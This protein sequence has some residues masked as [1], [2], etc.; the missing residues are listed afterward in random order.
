MTDNYLSFD[1]FR[2]MCADHGEVEDEGQERLA[3]FLNVLGVALNYRQDPR[4]H[5]T[6]V[7]KPSWV[8]EGIYAI[9]NAKR[10][11]ENKGELKLAELSKILDPKHYPR[12]QHSFLIELMRKFELCFRF[13]EEE[14]RFLVPELLAKQEPEAVGSFTKEGQ[15]TFEYHY[16][17]LLPEGLLPR[18]IVRTSGLSS[19]QLRWRTGVLLSFEGNRA[20]VRGDPLGRKICIAVDGPTLGRRRLLAVIRFDFEQIHRTYA[21]RPDEMVPVP[22][23][24][25]MV[26]AYKK[27]LT[28]E[29]NGEAL[30]KE[31]FG[32]EVVTLNVRELLDG[33]DLEGVRRSRADPGHLQSPL[34]AFISYSHED[35]ALRAEM[36]THLKLL[37]RQGLL[38][39]WSDRC[40]LAGSDWQKQ[41]DE[42][43][44]SADLILLLVS[45]DFIA[46]DYCW[47][48]ELK[49]AMERHA[50]NEARVLPIIVRECSWKSTPFGKLKALPN[51]GR[52]VATWGTE[53]YS[54]DAPWTIIEEGIRSVIKDIRDYKSRRLQ[55]HYS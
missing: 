28:F 38:D 42:G 36:E 20:L 52:P 7:L 5:E 39:L 31:I 19:D 22:G 41:I 6:H 35:E 53:P 50:G 14:D 15:L 26:M 11:A 8:T 44:E 43:L 48:V 24:A 45:A 40:I 12:A 3:E 55:M 17:G 13:P 32:D 54:R 47:G 23:F 1:A 9:L 34:S 27:L 51:D 37:K 16:P 33:V 10:L 4:L 49:R 29:R 18:F 2:E 21:F 30:I 46:S 25:G